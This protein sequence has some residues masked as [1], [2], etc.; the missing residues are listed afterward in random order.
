MTIFW[1][2]VGVV[3]LVLLS[4]VWGMLCYKNHHLPDHEKRNILSKTLEDLFEKA[5]VIDDP[6]FFFN[7]D[8][9]PELR[10]TLWKKGKTAGWGAETANG[11]FVVTKF[12]YRTIDDSKG[13]RQ[14]AK[15]VFVNHQFDRYH[16]ALCEDL[17]NEAYN[18]VAFLH[19][20]KFGG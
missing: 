4:F 15:K 10:S 14:R 6:K 11:V 18:I 5:P 20:F 2:V 9:G 17:H 1:I 13:I 16:K 19:G 12:S 7:G 8:D 3:F